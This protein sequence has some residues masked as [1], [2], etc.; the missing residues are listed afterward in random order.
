[1]LMGQK[2][3]LKVEQRIRNQFSGRR[4]A[5]QQLTRLRS[6][7]S[8]LLKRDIPPLFLMYTSRDSKTALAQR[9]ELGGKVL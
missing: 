5:H 9:G 3:A 8:R 4:D 7:P 6:S 1:M 2:K